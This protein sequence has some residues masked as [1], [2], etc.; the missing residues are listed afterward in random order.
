MADSEF[1]GGGSR[2]AGSGLEE[3][4][5]VSLGLDLG[6]DARSVSLGLDHGGSNADSASVSVSLDVTDVNAGAGEERIRRLRADRKEKVELKVIEEQ[7]VLNSL[8]LHLTI[9][10]EQGVCRVTTTC[11]K[12]RGAV[13]APAAMG[14]KGSNGNGIRYHVN[15]NGR[16]V[17]V[18]EPRDRERSHYTITNTNSSGAGADGVNHARLVGNTTHNNNSKHSRQQIASAREAL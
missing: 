1:D 13:P 17:P 14:A 6:G 7:V 15:S 18:A 2:G 4:A 11:L 9:D 12:H 10:T 5:T 8:D 3:E 16:V